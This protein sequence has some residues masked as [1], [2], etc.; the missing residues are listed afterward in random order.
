MVKVTDTR[1]LWS[2]DKAER[3]LGLKCRSV[4]QAWLDTLIAESTPVS[5]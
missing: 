2:A 3:E 4:E 5:E 1:Y